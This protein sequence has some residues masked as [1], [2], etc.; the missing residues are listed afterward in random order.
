MVTGDGQCKIGDYGLS[1]KFTNNVKEGDSSISMGLWAGTELFMPP[2]RMLGLAM[3]ENDKNF[4]KSDVWGLGLITLILCLQSFDF[5]KRRQ[6][7]TQT[8]RDKRIYSKKEYFERIPTEHYSTN[9]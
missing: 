3:D 9:L 4:Y 2:E 1:K 7:E 5:L 8:M 6:N